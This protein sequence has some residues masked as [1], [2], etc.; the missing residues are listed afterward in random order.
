V[1]LAAWAVFAFAGTHAWT[2]LPLVAAAL[3]LAAS[4]RPALAAR[5]ELLDGAL[6]CCLA[7][8]ALQLLPLP[9]PLRSV[10]SP[11]RAAVEAQLV[12]APPGTAPLTLDP[13]ATARALAVGVALVLIFLSARALFE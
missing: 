9:A 6:F 13:A 8:T 7:L 5:G 11:N 12:F 2:L 10:L 3:A 1:A 4:V